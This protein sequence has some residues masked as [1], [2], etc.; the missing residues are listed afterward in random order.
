M[1]QQKKIKK[2]KTLLV[3]LSH[4]YVRSVGF[5]FVRFDGAKHFAG[6][7]E[8]E[9]KHFLEIISFIFQQVM[10]TP[11]ITQFQDHTSVVERRLYYNVP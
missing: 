10:Q 7:D 11:A 2:K 4:R 1:Q 6:H 5:E 8:I 9:A 3:L